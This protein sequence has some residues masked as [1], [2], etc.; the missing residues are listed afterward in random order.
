MLHAFHFGGCQNLDL[1]IL[2]LGQTAGEHSWVSLTAPSLIAPDRG[3]QT[4]R[5]QRRNAYRRVS[6]A[7]RRMHEQEAQQASSALSQAA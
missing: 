2:C 5:F 4:I 3:D 1:T 7:Y 6:V